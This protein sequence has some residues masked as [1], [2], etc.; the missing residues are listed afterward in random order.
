MSPAKNPCLN[1]H[2]AFKAHSL[3]PHHPA[4][5]WQIEGTTNSADSAA[6]DMHTVCNVDNTV[7]S[8]FLHKDTAP[9]NTALTC[10]AV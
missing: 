8:L 7:T 4:P 10:G 2:S 6:L 5:H 3:S 1:S 9:A